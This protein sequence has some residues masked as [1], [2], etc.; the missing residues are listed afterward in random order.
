[1]AQPYYDFERER[2]KR[3]FES[4]DVEN[5]GVLSRGDIINYFLKEEGE[6]ATIFAD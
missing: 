1:V 5:K 6:Q 4:M 3:L 2:I